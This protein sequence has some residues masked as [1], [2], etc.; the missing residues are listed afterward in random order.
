MTV[1][2]CDGAEELVTFST[3]T[4]LDDTTIEAALAVA[5]TAVAATTPVK[6]KENNEFREH[7]L[8]EKEIAARQVYSSRH[9]YTNAICQVSE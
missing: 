2:T 6:G 4:D 5:P 1:G 8:V 7:K 3:G 9:K